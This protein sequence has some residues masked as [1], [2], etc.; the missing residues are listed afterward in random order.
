MSASHSDGWVGRERD[1]YDK[2]DHKFAI[3]AVCTCSSVLLSTPL[4]AGPPCTNSQGQHRSPRSGHLS[5]Y[6]TDD[7][8]PSLATPTSHLTGPSLPATSLPG[9]SGPAP[10]GAPLACTL[11]NPDAS[12]VSPAQAWPLL[13]SQPHLNAQ[14]APP[15]PPA[16]HRTPVPPALRPRLLSQALPWGHDPGLKPHSDVGLTPF[17]S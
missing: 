2:N 12:A 11:V 9:G 8:S 5:R 4:Q 7:L 3:L 15:A 14:P 1:L 16:E 6:Q 13:A 17:F 10:L